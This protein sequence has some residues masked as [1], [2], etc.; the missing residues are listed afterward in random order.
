MCSLAP[1]WTEMGIF[2]WPVESGPVVLCSFPN[3]HLC[4]ISWCCSEPFT[5]TGQSTS[6]QTEVP[7][8]GEVVL[9]QQLCRHALGPDQELDKEVAVWPPSPEM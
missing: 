2:C 8:G 6:Y 5:R 1:A 9:R 3:A 7:Q 4:H